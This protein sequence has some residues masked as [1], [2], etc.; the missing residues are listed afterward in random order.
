MPVFEN[1]VAIF[2]FT[3]KDD[4]G[5]IL[6]QT[7]KNHPAHALIGSGELLPQLEEML[8]KVENGDSFSLHLSASEAYGEHNTDLEIDVDINEFPEKP[9]VGEAYFIDDDEEAFPYVVKAIEN[10]VVKMDG[11][12]AF[13]GRNVSFE[14]KLIDSREATEEEL[15][16]GHA[17]VPGHDHN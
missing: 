13:A 15:D 9:N 3:L 5:E 10:E 1:Q 17:H 12:H 14:I 11:N 4:S 16:H 7:D 8:G 6:E 2:H